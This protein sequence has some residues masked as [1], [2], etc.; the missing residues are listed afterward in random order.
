MPERPKILLLDDDQELL[1][2][3]R[4]MLQ[5]LPSSPEVRIAAS[6]ARAIA[7]LESEPFNLLIS[8]LNMPKMDGLQVLTVVRRK[9]PN[10][11]TAVMTS[12]ADPQYRTRAYAMGIDLFLEKPNT[13]QEI[14]LFLECVDSLLFRNEVDAGFRGV[15]SKSLMDIIQ[16]ESLSH[17]SCVL[18][19][20][21][22]PSTARIWFENG[23]IIDAECPECKG[24]PAVRK[25]LSWRAGAFETLPA[26]LNRPRT[27]NT[28][29]QGL[30]LDAAQ[31]VD[32]AIA[33]EVS[34]PGPAADPAEPAEQE[35][36][37]APL[38]RLPGVEFVMTLN[39]E[40]RAAESWGVENPDRLAE[41]LL[42]TTSQFEALGEKLHAGRLVQY[43]ALTTRNH[44]VTVPHNGSTLC[45][46]FDRTPGAHAIRETAEKLVALWLS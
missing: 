11:R 36:P 44:L 41:W 33:A 39:R 35:S 30:L 3:Y 22:G 15:Q 18:K 26:E 13:P 38:T 8:D 34:T 23:E 46:G 20:T 43:E 37:L 6:G 16:M 7:L 1:E 10:L 4:E 14:K 29:V 21:N 40:Q 17:S 31:A 2:L 5:R 42:E 25:I 27:V 19:V 24:E 9:F 28:S 45:A 12:L 32:E